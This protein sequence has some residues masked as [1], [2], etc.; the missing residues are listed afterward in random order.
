MHMIVD[1]LLTTEQLTSPKR[2]IYEICEMYGWDFPECTSTADGFI[3][4][5]E[6]VTFAK[7]RKRQRLIQ[8]A[9]IRLGT[10]MVDSNINVTSKG[11]YITA[12][13]IPSY[14]S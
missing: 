5:Y 3:I 11:N 12:A 9:C 2:Y 4:K 14:V 13:L 6:D 1:E 7:A 8:D 10:Q